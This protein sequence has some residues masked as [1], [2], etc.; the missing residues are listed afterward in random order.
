MEPDLFLSFEII[1]KTK[2]YKTKNEAS[3]QNVCTERVR[4]VSKLNFD[5]HIESERHAE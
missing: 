2:K 4:A 1:K 3:A 5:F